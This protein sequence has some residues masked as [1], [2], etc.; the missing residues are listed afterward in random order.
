VGGGIRAHINKDDLC[1]FTALDLASS[2]DR[3]CCSEI[4]Y[5]HHAISLRRSVPQ[6]RL[7]EIDGPES[8]VLSIRV[9]F[10][11]RRALELDSKSARIRLTNRARLSS[12]LTFC[13]RRIRGRRLQ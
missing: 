4:P 10:Y 7:Y 13:L 3:A 2:T 1:A 8:F 9:P 5:K 6:L 11:K 12:L